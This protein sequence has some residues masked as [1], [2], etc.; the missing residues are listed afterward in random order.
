MSPGN[1]EL[2]LLEVTRLNISANAFN[3]EETAQIEVYCTMS[4]DP[5]PW[6]CLMQYAGI[7]Y[8]VLDLIISKTPQQQLGVV[9]K[10]DV[11]PEVGTSCVI[12][13]TIVSGSPAAI[14]EMRRGDILIAV[15]GKKVLNMNQ[16][17]K[18]VKS[19]AQR[20]F[21]I[22]VERKYVRSDLERHVSLKSETE[23]TATDKIVEKKTGKNEIQKADCTGTEKSS[24][25]QKNSKFDTP[26]KFSELKETDFEMLD[27]DDGKPYRRKGSATYS[28]EEAPQTPSCPESPSRRISTISTISNQSLITNISQ[29][30]SNDDGAVQNMTDLYY[31]TKE[32]SVASLISFDETRNFQ[33]DSDLQYLNL[34]VWARVKGG[35]NP[36]LL[37]GYINAPIKLILAQCS[38]STIGHYLKCYALLPP[39]TGLLHKILLNCAVHRSV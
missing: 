32:K 5:T 9:F 26:I 17:A 15:D 36:P 10:Q 25:D 14:A 22:R 8:M 24:P 23:K 16:V 2:T 28:T 13:E 34:G 7:T 39:D 18:F 1:L 3:I 21:I 27:L 19:A 12:V 30:Y 33:I 29:M 6:V 11:I 38:V 37:L 31:T 20:R 4:V 35:D